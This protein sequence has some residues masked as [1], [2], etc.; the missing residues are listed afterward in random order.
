MARVESRVDAHKGLIFLSKVPETIEIPAGQFTMGISRNKIEKLAREQ[1]PVARWKEKNYFSREMPHH[2]ILL[3]TFHIGRY[4]VT[5]GEFR[6]FLDEGG[7]QDGG[8]WC[9]DGLKW[10]ETADRHQPN[11]WDDA[12]WSGS[13]ELPVVGVSWYEASAY[14]RWLSEIPGLHYR[15]PREAEWEKASRG[16]DGRMYP[17]GDEFDSKLCN[18]NE[19]DYGKTTPVGLFSPRGDSPYGCS[20]MAGNVSEWTA[21]RFEPYPFDTES[22]DPEG[23]YNESTASLRVLR[24]GSWHSNALRVRTTSRGMND[25]WFTDNDVGF[26]IAL[27]TP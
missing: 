1:E 11:N 8:L 15:L 18:M 10:L 6:Q 21:S 5:V 7:Y 12:I 19:G 9:R 23:R 4:P 27:S 26:R 16:E 13:S 25:P 2:V 14:C 20:D 24:G 3:P 22:I 17:W